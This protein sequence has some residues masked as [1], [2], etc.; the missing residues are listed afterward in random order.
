MVRLLMFFIFAQL[1]LMTGPVYSQDKTERDLIRWLNSKPS[2]KKIIVEGNDKEIFSD[3]KIRSQMFSRENNLLRAIRGDRSRKLQRESL[4]RDTSGIKYLYLSQGFLGVQVDEKFEPIL[5]DSG[6]AKIIVNIKEGR[7]FVCDEVTFAGEY[8]EELSA[9]LEKVGGK[10]RK[11]DVLNPF[12][13]REVVL[14]MK[15]LLAN[16]GYPYASINYSLDTLTEPPQ[17]DIL[18]TVISDSLVHFGPVHVNGIKEYQEAVVNR[19]ITINSGDV[20][21]RKEIINTQQ[22][23]LESG[24]YLTL[25]LNPDDKVNPAAFDRL[26]PNFIL[27]LKEKKPHYISLKTGAA[28][29]S[30]KDLTW[31]LAASWGKRNLF[32][33]RRLEL[34]ASSAFIVITDWRLKEHFYRARLT[35]PWFLGIRMPLTLSAQ[36]SPGVRTPIEDQDYRKQSWS[37]TASTYR[38][39]GTKLVIQTGFEYE[40]VNIYGLSEEQQIILKREEGIRVQRK[41]FADIT[42]D[43]RNNLFVPST[44]SFTT[45]HGEYVGGILNGD[46]SFLN[47]Q[48]SWS[49]YQV[50]WP[51]WIMAT[52]FKLGVVREF[53]KSES[54]P[55][56]DRLYLGGA[57]SIRGFSEKGLGPQVIDENGNSIPE[58]SNILLIG[59]LEF[60]YP[61]LGKFWGSLF[62]DGGNGFRN[63]EEIDWDLMAFS[64]GT[65]LQF[66]SPAGPIRLDYARRIKTKYYSFDERFHLTILYAF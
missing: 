59:N 55:I 11:S 27:N 50:V 62:L 54:V 46:D 14:E 4:W 61:I 63:Q 12:K 18:F 16:N 43:S 5:P 3:K 23:L 9:E 32:G 35:E 51:G 48:T 29:D 34:T 42:R 44:G 13:A 28:Q 53:G 38:K 1:V 24:N 31:T 57:N 40:E 45:I 58:G 8:P 65:G 2:I 56:D 41:V 39:I 17:T 19:E 49:R 47:F 33:S 15:A 25:S 66:L 21:R 20:Y 22:R 37:L 30:L 64:Y 52:R 36:L 7:Q 26:N 10:F 6:T 60:R